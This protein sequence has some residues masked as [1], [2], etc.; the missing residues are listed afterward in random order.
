VYVVLRLWKPPLRKASHF[1]F[2]G[3][4]PEARM[5]IPPECVE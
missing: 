1:A 5:R 3:V 4:P 2:S